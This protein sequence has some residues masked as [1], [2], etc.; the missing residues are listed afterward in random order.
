MGFTESR[1]GTESSTNAVK[2][3]ERNKHSECKA[4]HYLSIKVKLHVV[5]K[6]IHA[7]MANGAWK[8]LM[9]SYYGHGVEEIL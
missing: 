2:E 1:V 8:I 5:K 7:N 9:N 6:F 4:F 3:L